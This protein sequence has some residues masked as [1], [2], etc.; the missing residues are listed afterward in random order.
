VSELLQAFHQS[1]FKL[2]LVQPVK[3]IP[4]QFNVFCTMTQQCASVSSN[5]FHRFQEAFSCLGD[6]ISGQ[7]SKYL[8]QMKLFISYQRQ[9]PIV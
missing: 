7:Q 6:L 4:T 3:V 8:P 9:Q 5:G 2:L 1:A